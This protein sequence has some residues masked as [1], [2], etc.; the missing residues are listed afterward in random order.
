MLNKASLNQIKMN[1]KGIYCRLMV[2]GRF[3]SVNNYKVDRKI[4]SLIV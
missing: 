1:M 2:Q 4:V 3:W